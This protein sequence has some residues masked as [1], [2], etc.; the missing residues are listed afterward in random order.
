MTPEEVAH[1]RGD[2]SPDQI[3]SLIG[4]VVELDAEVGESDSH[5]RPFM[6][7]GQN[8]SAF[9]RLAVIPAS[10]DELLPRAPGSRPVEGSLS[11][12]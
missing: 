9:K 3:D 5:P 1:S 7:S 8:D 10:R 12:V 4:K 2:Q 11:E 6:F